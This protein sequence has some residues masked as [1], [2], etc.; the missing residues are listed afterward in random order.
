MAFCDFGEERQVLLRCARGIA[1]KRHRLWADRRFDLP[2]FEST[3][4]RIGLPVRGPNVDQ[5]G[6]GNGYRSVVTI[7]MRARHEDLIGDVAGERKRLHPGDV[8][9][10]YGGSGSQG[11][12]G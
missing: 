4:S 2:G 7:A 12:S 3:Q 10:G 9:A 1:K 11:Q 5:L 6:T 8:E